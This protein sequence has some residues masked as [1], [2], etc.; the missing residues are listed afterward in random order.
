MKSSSAELPCLCEDDDRRG[1]FGRVAERCSPGGR[2]RGWGLGG[3][4]KDGA[5]GLGKCS[6]SH[7]LSRFGHGPLG[8]LPSKRYSMPP[9]RPL[10]LE[11]Y[12]K[13]NMVVR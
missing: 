10:A 7:T 5:A 8:S 11:T 4:G 6:H 3:N 12:Y 1:M 2:E 9:N 13:T